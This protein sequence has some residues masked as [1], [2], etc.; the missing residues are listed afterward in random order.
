LYGNG[1][2]NT[3]NQFISNVAANGGGG[4]IDVVQSHVTS[5][6]N[7]FETNTSTTGGGALLLRL[8]QM[9]SVEDIFR[10][11]EAGVS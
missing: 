9:T 4:A 1:L 8:S 6:G 5:K 11:N 10:N 3:C 7:T 2:A